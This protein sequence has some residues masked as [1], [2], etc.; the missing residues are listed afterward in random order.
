M[1]IQAK[2]GKLIFLQGVISP[3][4]SIGRGLLVGLYTLRIKGKQ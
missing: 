4:F 1:I 2:E 3:D